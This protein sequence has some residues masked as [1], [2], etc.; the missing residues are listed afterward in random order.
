MNLETYRI[1]PDSTFSLA[2]CDPGDTAGLTDKKAA[3]KD[4]KAVRKRIRALQERL[5]AEKRQS[6]L[7]ILQATDTGGK[8]GTISHVFRDVNQQGCRVYAFKEP[9][10]IEL[11]HDFLWRCHQQTPPDGFITIFNRS[12][13][14]DVLVARVKN[15]VEQPVWE[16]RY[17]Q[18]NDFERL[19]GENGTHIL[20][21]FLHI[22]REEQKE[23]LQARLD[24]PEKNWKFSKGD[25]ADRA[26]W[27]DY[28]AAY[29]DTIARCSTDVAP[30]YVIPADYKWFRN[31]LVARIIEKTLIEM[32]PQFP[33]PESGLDDIVIPD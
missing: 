25:L 3:K 8:D 32:N 2:E 26:L 18:I 12:H 19:L 1:G 10:E 17:G 31:L 23:R 22:S 29:H 5:W 27:D 20:K 14:E 11:A 15:L 13:Y 16:R 7:V 21:F 33:E 30:W 9:T 4:L 24:D 28:Q 6:L